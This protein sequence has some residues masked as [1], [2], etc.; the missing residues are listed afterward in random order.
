MKSKGFKTTYHINNSYTVLADCND[1]ILTL[2]KD[3]YDYKAYTNSLDIFLYDETPM[4]LTCKD[5]N[6]NKVSKDLSGAD[7][8]S[9][10]KYG[11]VYHVDFDK[12]IDMHSIAME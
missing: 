7:Y 11:K 2:D 5:I 1:L 8:I 3:G 6:G 9:S 10:G 12:D 4:I